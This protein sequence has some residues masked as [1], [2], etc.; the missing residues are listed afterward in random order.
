[1]IQGVNRR[2]FIEDYNKEEGHNFRRPGRRSVESDA[3]VKSSS[4]ADQKNRGFHLKFLR[5]EIIVF[6]SD[7]LQ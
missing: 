7:R 2:F 4:E 6:S 3:H 5:R 1:M